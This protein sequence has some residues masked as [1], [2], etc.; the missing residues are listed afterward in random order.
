MVVI[1]YLKW[2]QHLISQHL[3]KILCPELG[4]K[5]SVKISGLI[6]PKTTKI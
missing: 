2:D 4:K 3:N 1:L 6:A 5:N